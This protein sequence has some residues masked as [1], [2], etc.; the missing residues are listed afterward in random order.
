MIIA[1]LVAAAVLV[2]T[3]PFSLSAMDRLIRREHDAHRGDWERD[4]RPIGSFFL[5]PEA[6]A[7]RSRFAFYF[8]T[9]VWLFSTPQW[10]RGDPA[11][12]VLLRRLRWSTSIGNAAALALLYVL[13]H[14]VV[15]T[16]FA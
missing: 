5:A 2:T 4:G 15:A 11:A 6:R 12:A 16:S 9:L 14:F 13:W 1:L 10:V 8:C 3:I 7:L